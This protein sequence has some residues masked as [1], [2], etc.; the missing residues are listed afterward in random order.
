MRRGGINCGKCHIE[1][2][3]YC[4]SDQSI[5]CPEIKMCIL[6]HSCLPEYW[7][8]GGMQNLNHIYEIPSNIYIPFD[9]NLMS[10]THTFGHEDFNNNIV[11]NAGLMIVLY[12]QNTGQLYLIAYRRGIQG[13]M[14][15][16]KELCTAGGKIEIWQTTTMAILAELYEEM[17]LLLPEYAIQSN[18]VIHNFAMGFT[19][20]SV[21]NIQNCKTTGP[22]IGH[23]YEVFNEE[24]PNILYPGH[25]HLGNY[26]YAIPIEEFFKRPGILLNKFSSSL[27]QFI[28]TLIL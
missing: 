25:Y 12:D 13:D 6:D 28:N 22:I 17:G 3:H 5:N 14:N 10:L 15:Y 21:S 18:W 23:E 26:I 1:Q 4:N 8:N 19:A 11:Q 24:M 2:D 20:I 27:Y 7:H 16:Q 9:G